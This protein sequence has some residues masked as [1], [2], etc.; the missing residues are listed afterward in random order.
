MY[1]WSACSLQNNCVKRLS[2]CGRAGYIDFVL[3]SCDWGVRIFEALAAHVFQIFPDVLGVV[4]NKK[5]L[6]LGLRRLGP[7]KSDRIV[8]GCNANSTHFCL[9]SKLHYFLITHGRKL[10]FSGFSKAHL[11]HSN[12]SSLQLQ[13]S[14]MKK[15]T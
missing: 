3:R 9:T 15:K 12:L 1:H 6:F 10:S 11:G 5:L 4:Q 14:L 2:T 7:G 8:L 13:C